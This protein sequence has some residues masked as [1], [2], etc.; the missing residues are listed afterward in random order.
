M[1]II[2]PLI[3]TGLPADNDPIRPD[4]DLSYIDWVANP[5][6]TC[7]VTVAKYEVNRLTITRAQAREQLRRMNILNAVDNMI[8]ASGNESAIDYW[9]TSP[10]ITRYSPAVMHFGQAIKALGIDNNFDLD[11]FFSEA[12][13]IYI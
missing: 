13:N 10:T 4:T 1:K 3:G 9:N 6:G 8:E 11:Y 2:V 12:N 5:D 7:T